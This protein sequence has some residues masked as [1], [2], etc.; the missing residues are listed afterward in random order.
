MLGNRKFPGLVDLIRCPQSWWKVRLQWP[1][2]AESAGRLIEL[3]EMPTQ[4]GQKPFFLRKEIVTMAHGVETVKTH[5]KRPWCWERLRSRGERGQQRVRWLDGIRLNGHEFE[6]T[7]GDSQG[8]GS[9][10]GRS[11]WGHKESDR[12]ERLNNNNNRTWRKKPHSPMWMFCSRR[13]CVCSFN[14]HTGS[15]SNLETGEDLSIVCFKFSVYLRKKVRQRKIRPEK[16]KALMLPSFS[17]SISATPFPERIL[18]PR[19]AG[20]LLVK[21]SLFF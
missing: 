8:Q 5:W 12:T 16:I 4:E 7:Q 21:G 10:V 3:G 1:I 20:T 19:Q 14:T 17:S 15:Q 9:L 2:M 13:F 11:P 6:Q 18:T